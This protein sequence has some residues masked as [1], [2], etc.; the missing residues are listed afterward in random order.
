MVNN[1]SDEIAESALLAWY[2]LVLTAHRCRCIVNCAVYLA[3]MGVLCW[4]VFAS[5]GMR[6]LSVALPFGIL[7]HAKHVSP[8]LAY[9]PSDT[10]LRQKYLQFVVASS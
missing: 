7:S 10:P 3:S 5:M 8:L 2:S 1:C 9:R 6:L 4:R